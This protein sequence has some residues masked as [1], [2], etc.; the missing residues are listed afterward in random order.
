MENAPLTLAEGPL[1]PQAYEVKKLMKFKRNIGQQLE[2]IGVM[3]Q[4]LVSGFRA[5]KSK[6]SLDSELWPCAIAPSDLPA[7]R[8]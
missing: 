6:R 4:S 2:G 1:A 7:S 3:V 8:A 5:V